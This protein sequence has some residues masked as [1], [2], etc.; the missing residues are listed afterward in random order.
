MLKN[1][2]EQMVCCLEYVA[3]FRI[4]VIQVAISQNSQIK[5]PL[6]ARFDEI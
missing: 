6:T 3:L 2:L 1:I 5:F 4:D